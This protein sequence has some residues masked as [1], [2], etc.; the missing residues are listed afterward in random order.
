[1]PRPAEFARHSVRVE[2]ET[3]VARQVLWIGL[4]FAFVGLSG[5]VWSWRES[6]RITEVGLDRVGLS[7]VRHWSQLGG[8]PRS[9]VV[10]RRLGAASAIAGFVVAVG[11]LLS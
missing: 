3:G 9:I 2:R 10:G 1:M 6:L 11:A 4:S 7:T 5:F 8:I